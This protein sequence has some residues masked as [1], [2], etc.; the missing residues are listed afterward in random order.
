[1]LCCMVK[2]REKTSTRTVFSVTNG[3]AAVLLYAVLGKSFL[4]GIEWVNKS[5]S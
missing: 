2:A 3:G 4:A 5:N 1:M